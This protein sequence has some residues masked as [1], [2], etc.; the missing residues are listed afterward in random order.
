MRRLAGVVA[1][2]FLAAAL[3]TSAAPAV[4]AVPPSVPS[5]NVLVS[6]ADNNVDAGG[7]HTEEFGAATPAARLLWISAKTQIIK[8]Q[9]TEFLLPNDY[10]IRCDATDPS[11]RSILTAPFTGSTG[12]TD[13][14]RL[15]VRT[16]AVTLRNGIAVTVHCS[17][18]VGQSNR[19][20]FWHLQ[21]NLKAG[22]VISL[23]DSVVKQTSEVDQTNWWGSNFGSSAEIPI[24]PG[25]RMRI[26]SPAGFWKTAGVPATITVSI[27]GQQPVL[28]LN[29]TN[30]GSILGFTVPP[31]VPVGSILNVSVL[32]TTVLDAG[33][34]TTPVRLKKT[35]WVTPLDIVAAG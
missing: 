11:G 21:T 23:T 22:Q 12:P 31:T 6:P 17:L 29:V 25:E 8:I 30:D 27:F 7:S 5:V 15:A 16:G 19:D 18:S 33:S 13:T 26:Y 32:S 24:A 4:L 14:V 9:S 34:A 35:G 2:V 10:A 28:D 20:S 1:A 3:A